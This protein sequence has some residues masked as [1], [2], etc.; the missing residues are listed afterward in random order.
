MKHTKI[1]TTIL[2]LL[3]SIFSFGCGE[4]PVDNENLYTGDLLLYDLGFEYETQYTEEE[5]IERITART[6]ENLA[7]DITSDKIEKIEVEIVYSLYTKDPEYFLIEVEYKQ[8][9]TGYWSSSNIPYSTKHKH[10]FGMIY[11]DNYIKTPHM[12]DFID[13]QSIYRARGYKNNVKYHS[14]FCFAIEEGDKLYQLFPETGLHK[15][16][17]VLMLSEYPHEAIDYNIFRELTTMQQVYL[18]KRSR[19]LISG[20]YFWHFPELY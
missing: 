14:S 13:G 18:L 19:A 11:C 16:N 7:E 6:E 9:F 12:D 17:T 8:E 15:F 3:I 4:N 5:H 2:A 10:F 20:N 1:F